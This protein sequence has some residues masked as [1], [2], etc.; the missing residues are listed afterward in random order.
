[1]KDILFSPITTTVLDLLIVFLIFGLVIIVIECRLIKVSRLLDKQ[2]EESME[3]SMEMI[4]EIE[5]SEDELIDEVNKICIR[6]ISGISMVVIT[7]GEEPHLGMHVYP[8]TSIKRLYIGN[9]V[10]KNNKLFDNNVR[11]Y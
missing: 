9:L 4:V 5:G 8:L 10:S 1:M 7:V 3:T 6:K 2:N 11:C